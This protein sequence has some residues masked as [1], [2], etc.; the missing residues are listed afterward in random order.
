M[1]LIFVTAPR[2]LLQVLELATKS[3]VPTSGVM[4]LPIASPAVLPVR[5]LALDTVSPT[6]PLLATT[7]RPVA[8][9]SSVTAP[10]AP[11]HVGVEAT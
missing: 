3:L 10:T 5:L 1:P 9:S 2:P 4:P 6:V 8:P 7:V 11:F